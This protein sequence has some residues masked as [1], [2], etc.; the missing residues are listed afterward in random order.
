MIPKFGL[1]SESQDSRLTVFVI[2]FT[3]PR[4]C[5][6]LG[7][8]KLLEYSYSNLLQ[9]PWWEGALALPEPRNILCKENLSSPPE[10]C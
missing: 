7:T 10:F 6:F 3:P 5:K 1:R 9:F 2:D 4:C 8:E